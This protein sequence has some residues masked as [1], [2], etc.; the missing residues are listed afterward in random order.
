LYNILIEFSLPMKL[1]R[2]DRNK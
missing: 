1:F 2:K